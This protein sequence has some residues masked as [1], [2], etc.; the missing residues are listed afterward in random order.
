ML[1][2]GKTLGK[3]VMGLR[4]IGANGHPLSLSG[5][6]ARNFMRQ[7]ELFLPL[8]AGAGLVGPTSTLSSLVSLAWALRVLAQ[9]KKSWTHIPEF[10]ALLPNAQTA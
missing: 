3:H 6:V 2:Q 7:V 4:V 10:V 8:I 5:L 9:V 1:W